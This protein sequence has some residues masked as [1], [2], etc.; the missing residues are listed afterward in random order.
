[1]LLHHLSNVVAI[2]FHFFVRTAKSYR[3]ERKAE[4]SSPIRR[5]SCIEGMYEVI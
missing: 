4:Q 1:M 3:E 5:K 2:D